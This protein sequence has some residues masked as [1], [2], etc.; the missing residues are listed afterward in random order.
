MI[1][2]EC[3]VRLVQDVYIMSVGNE[4]GKISSGIHT[5]AITKE[6]MVVM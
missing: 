1:I 5:M 6:K 4:E 2:A 3:A